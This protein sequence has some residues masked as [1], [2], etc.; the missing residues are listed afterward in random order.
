[1]KKL[2]A[3]DGLPDQICQQ[4]AYQVDTTY[5]FKL[6]CESSDATLRQSLINQTIQHSPHEI[7]L[8]VLDTGCGIDSSNNTTIKHEVK[9]EIF[10]EEN[11]VHPENNEERICNDAFI[12][13]STDSWTNLQTETSSS[14]LVLKKAPKKKQSSSPRKIITKNCKNQQAF[15]QKINVKA[16]KQVKQGYNSLTGANAKSG[17]EEPVYVCEKESVS[18]DFVKDDDDNESV[19]NEFGVEV[20]MRKKSYIKLFHCHDCGKN[21]A[22]KTQLVLH[23]SAHTGA[24]PYICSQ[25]GR[26]FASRINLKKH[27]FTHTGEKPYLCTRCGIS[28]GRIDTLTKHMRSHTGEKPFHCSVCGNNFARRSTFTNHMRTHSGEKPYLCTECGWRCV[29]SYDLKKHMRCH[30]GEKPFRCTICRMSFGQRNSLTKHMK[31]HI[32]DVPLTLECAKELQY[33]C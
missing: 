22:K 7:F 32:G 8:T 11:H 26:T 27:L 29:Q 3:G 1:M 14:K 6:Q 31:C 23:M 9:E 24:K 15:S 19:S 18:V 33:Q 5:K 12:E 13:S 30:T 21:F 28:F 20:Q 2:S 10:V 16:C 4:C 25:C 17:S